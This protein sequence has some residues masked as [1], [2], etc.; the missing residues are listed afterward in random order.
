MKRILQI[1]LLVAMTAVLTSCNIKYS[2]GSRVGVVQKLSKKGFFC[3]TYE[4]EML[5]NTTST[6]FPEKFKF[7]VADTVTLV[8][9]E[10]A[11][12]STKP[13]QMEY[14]Q[15]LLRP[16]CSPDSPYQITDVEYI[17]GTSTTANATG[18]SGT[19]TN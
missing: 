12:A 19:D 7:S 6:A 1:V 11:L 5:V 14:Q 18:G 2:E 15:L 16:P 10:A 4:G 17:D 13:V 3:Q 9:V 8:K